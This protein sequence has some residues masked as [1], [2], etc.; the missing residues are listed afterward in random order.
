[1]GRGGAACWARD[2]VHATTRGSGRD[3]RSWREIVYKRH[4]I[5]EQIAVGHRFRRQAKAILPRCRL[6]DDPAIIAGQG[7]AGLELCAQA[8]ALGMKP[9]LVAAPASG[10]GSSPVSRRGEHR[11]RRD[12]MV[13]EPKD[14]AITDS[15]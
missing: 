11:G 9:D 1:M 4:R 7:T 8:E 14:F 10:G 5:P 2:I 12:V 6:Y 3:T 15:R 13:A